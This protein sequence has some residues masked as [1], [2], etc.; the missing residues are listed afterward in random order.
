MKLDDKF[1]PPAMSQGAGLVPVRFESPQA[2]L[3]AL[4]AERTFVEELR[5]K[6]S[7][8]F[9]NDYAV[10]QAL[11]ELS[12][13]F[14]QRTSKFQNLINQEANEERLKQVIAED[15]DRALPTTS[16]QSK[17]IRELAETDPLFALK[18]VICWYRIP[19]DYGQSRL[20]VD[21]FRASALAEF[22]SRGWIE[23]VDGLDSTLSNLSAA[24]DS[25]FQS[26]DEAHTQI[27]DQL[28]QS[29]TS[30]SGLLNSSQEQ[31]HA[32]IGQ[33]KLDVDRAIEDGRAKIEAVRETYKTELTLQAPTTYWKDKQ[34][35][36]RWISAA[37]MAA[38]TLF[39]FAT[40]VAVWEVWAVTVE[41]LLTE[42]VALTYGY[43]L[44]T[45]GVVFICVWILRILSRQI[46]TN[47]SLSS[48]AGERVAMVKTFLAL[49]QRPEHVKEPDR[50]LILSALFRPTSSQNE[51]GAPPS[52][53]DLVMQ[54]ISPK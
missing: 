49:M 52:W 36:H 35:A 19:A 1:S 38:F 28:S 21:W 23:N 48:D 33:H 22:L 11:Q 43:F 12:N 40:G 15:A 29:S 31:I 4:T 2:Y 14:N 27:I 8:Q 24:W 18:T 41:P 13:R 39:A 3:S 54:R 45:L 46:L 9:S 25:R 34:I 53:F 7:G 30:F 26:L 42:R 47:L 17:Y 6:S 32:A 50:V 10:G 16:A 5:R 20:L 51:D 37:W 44:P